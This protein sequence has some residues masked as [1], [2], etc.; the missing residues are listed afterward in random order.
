MNDPMASYLAT[1]AIGNY[2][3]VSAEPGLGIPVENTFPVDRIEISPGDFEQTDEM[4]EVFTELFG[5]YPFDE[6]GVMVVEDT[7]GFALETQGR[8]IFSQAIVDGDGSIERVVAHELAHQWFGNHVSPSTWQDIW[9]NEGFATY[10]E[11]LWLEFG[12]GAQIS[13]LEARLVERAFLIPLPAPGNPGSDNLFGASVYRRGGLTLHAL[14][15]DVGDAVFFDIL[16]EWSVRFGG[17]SASTADFVALSEELSGQD[18][19]AFFE[20]WL[21]S[22]AIPD[23]G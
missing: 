23:L 10:A 20:G 18:L 4:I 12:R 2:D 14:R 21:G 22:G 17:G 3:L 1:V 16:R 6:Y 7:F 13:D 15:I 8:S 9:L 5:P 19:D 11:D